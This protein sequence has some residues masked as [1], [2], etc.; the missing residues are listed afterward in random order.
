MTAGRRILRF[1]VMAVA[2]ILGVVVVAVGAVYAVSGRMLS[3][4]VTV[5]VPVE[6]IAIP[7]ADPT[8]VTRGQYLVDHVLGCKGCHAPDLGGRAEVNDP[9]IGKWWAPNLT[10]GR[11]SKTAAY[12]PVDW[13]R[14]IRHGVS[15]DGHRLILMPSADF[16]NFSNDDLGAVI[17]Y[18]KSVPPVDRDNEGI[19][20]GPIGRALLV[21]GHFK[22][23]FDE[24]DHLRPRSEA[25]P[26]AGREWGAVLV[27]ACIGCHGAGLSGGPI[28]G[29]PPDWP[30]T[31][32]LTPHETGLKGWTL[33]QFSQALRHGQRPDGTTLSTVMP[34]KAYAGMTDTDV[35]ALWAFLQTVAAKPSGGR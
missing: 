29:T 27:G 32:N 34:W 2:I 25:R 12:T 20:T 11:G 10:T 24:I 4:R 19:T 1:L 16:F 8:A 26:S 9:M 33:E 15:T 6:S 35:Q 5:P 7:S 13:V 18:I 31:R 21:A 30:P 23:A 14:S 3:A 28:P 17:A 22:F